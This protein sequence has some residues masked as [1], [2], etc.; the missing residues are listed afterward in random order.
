M[1]AETWHSALHR[2]QADA[3]P[4]VLISVVGAEGSTPREPGAKMVVT[5]ETSH[6]TLGGG[7]FEYQAIACARDMLAASARGEQTT[8]PHLEAFPLGGRSGQ[9]CGG[10]VSLLF[11]CFAGAENHI[12]IFGAGHVAQALVP[13][14]APLPWRIHWFDSRADV[15]T[16][17]APS[18]RVDCHRLDENAIET[19]LE[20]L[21][22][23]VH[24]LV[25]THDHTQ[26]RR[27]IDALLG[28]GGVASIGLIGSQSKWASFQR[29]LR[30]AGHDATALARVRCPI[31]IPGAGGKRPYEIALAIA[32]E[33]L[34]LAPAEVHAPQRGVL[35]TTWHHVTGQ[36]A[37]L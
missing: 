36:G 6:D 20:S 28:H 21:P 5:V 9:C 14:L 25:M 19:A 12:A 24:A 27:L 4:H 17:L 29:P 8:T 23:G 37:C 34:T 16:A 32:A 18:P 13:L 11:E 22:H 15:F 30:D 10:H 3:T 31:G 26:D 33:L 2:L 35:P 7:R 1:S